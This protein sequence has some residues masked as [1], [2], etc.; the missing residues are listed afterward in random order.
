RRHVAAI[1]E[2][3]RGAVPGHEI[4]PEVAR[5]QAEPALAPHVDLPQAVAPGIEALGEEGACLALGVD[6]RN[7]PAID[8]DLDLAVQAG[9]QDRLGGYCRHHRL[10]GASAGWTRI[11]P[12]QG[13]RRNPRSAVGAAAPYR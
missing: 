11:V 13:R 9:E 4:R 2:E 10:Q 3:P 6:V 1:E 5:G 12:L 7:P 8:Q